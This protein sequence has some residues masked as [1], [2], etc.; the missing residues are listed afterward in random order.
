M[1][2]RVALARALL[3]ESEVLVLDE[4]FTGLD[5]EN[6]DRAIAAI[7]RWAGRRTIIFV[8]HEGGFPGA[9]RMELHPP[10]P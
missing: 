8:S 1:Q 2:R 10:S 6:R 7:E 4:P 3:T 5:E 9:E